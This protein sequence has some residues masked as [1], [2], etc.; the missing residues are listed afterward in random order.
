MPTVP[1]MKVLVTH[2]GAVRARQ[3]R[4]RWL[5]KIRHAVTNL[6]RPTKRA[7]SP[8]DLSRSTQR[9]TQRGCRRSP[10]AAPTDVAAIKAAID[11]IFATWQPAY[12]V[13]LGG[14]ELLATVNL[15]N[16]LWTGDPND[17]PDQF[18]PSDLPYACDG[19]LTMSPGRLPRPDSRRRSHS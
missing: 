13:L 8:L 18:V 14:P 17:D 12:L 5:A 2:R 10:S 4:Q 19:P 15:T 16:P 9:P 1:V 3:V 6:S 7:E 11:A